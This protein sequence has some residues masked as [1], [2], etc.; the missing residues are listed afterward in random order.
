MS[1]LLT[2]H[3]N[4]IST[5]LQIASAYMQQNDPSHDL[6]HVNRVLKNALAIYAADFLPN[7][8][9]DERSAFERTL[10]CVV[11]LH[12]C[13]DKKYIKPEE[14]TEARRQFIARLISDLTID[15]SEAQRIL[16]LIEGISFSTQM[17]GKIPDHVQNHPVLAIARDAD[18]LD[19]IGAI[20][21]ARCCAF[22]AMKKRPI[23]VSE[24]FIGEGSSAVDHFHEKLLKLKDLFLTDAGRQLAHKRHEFLIAFLDQL[25][26]E[27]D[28]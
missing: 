6:H 25:Q 26:S 24:G 4:L 1:E 12:D 21:V 10:I 16:E 9:L 27:L 20:G 5:C 2:H 8:P 15:S 14:Y 28:V 13:L 11:T 3:S 7:A 19:A 23:V 18:R 22:S 17:A